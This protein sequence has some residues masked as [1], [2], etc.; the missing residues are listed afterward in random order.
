MLVPVMF[1][2][3][4]VAALGA[5]AGLLTG[6][7]EDPGSYPIARV[8][9]TLVSVDGVLQR[10]TS[11]D[12]SFVFNAIKP[13]AYQIEIAA[14]GFVREK[15]SVNVPDNGAPSPVVIRLRLC[16]L[17]A[18]M[19]CGSDFSVSYGPLGATNSHLQGMVYHVGGPVPIANA[20]VTIQ[21]VDD[22][23][24]ALRC[25]SDRSGRFTFDNVAAGI[26]HLKIAKRGYQP[27]EVKRLI[28]PRGHDVFI[29]TSTLE[30]GITIVE[31]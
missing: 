8:S 30:R 15:L 22:T 24:P 16:D 31:Q 5:S 26:Y 2:A 12:G 21:R 10:Q 18:P 28:K 9:V 19:T 17:P 1:L 25:R 11:E 20:E 29:Q 13:G 7:V 3:L 6:T 27:V 14:H 23:Q 4:G